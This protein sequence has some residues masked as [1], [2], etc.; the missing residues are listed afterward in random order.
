MGALSDLIPVFIEFD[1]EAFRF[2]FLYNSLIIQI[3]RLTFYLLEDTD[4]FHGYL[5]FEFF[6]LFHVR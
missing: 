2:Q 6:H 3:F 5:T 1:I 4:H